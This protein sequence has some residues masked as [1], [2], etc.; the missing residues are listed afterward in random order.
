MLS[1][2]KNYSY[3]K[4]YRKFRI[5]SKKQ[6]NAAFVIKAKKA[7]RVKKWLLCKVCSSYVFVILFHQPRQSVLIFMF[8]SGEW[9]DAQEVASQTIQLRN[10]LSHLVFLCS[11]ARAVQKINGD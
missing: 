7:E 5:L 1:F 8:L 2:E 3:K 10:V 6:K 4:N 9:S 11:G